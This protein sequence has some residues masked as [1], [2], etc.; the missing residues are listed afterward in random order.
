VK[1]EVGLWIDHRKAVIV[2]I[3]NDVEEIREIASDMEKRIRYSSGSRSNSRNNPQGSTSE[4]MRDRKFDNHLS[5]YYKEIIS[6][7]RD[8]DSILIFGPGEAKGELLTSLKNES[9]EGLVVG[10]ET[11][12]KMTDN[13]IAAKI[14]DHYLV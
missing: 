2:T 1:K 7:I 11:E 10:I 9:L 6:M 3:E 12:D 4:D 13:Q 8:A 5:Q 14:R